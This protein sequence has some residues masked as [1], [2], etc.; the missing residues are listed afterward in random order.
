[1]ENNEF[2]LD[3]I[4]KLLKSYNKDG[5]NNKTILDILRKDN[6]KYISIYSIV[7]YPDSSIY[8]ARNNPENTVREYVDD[9]D[10]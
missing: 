5:I 8:S 10:K 1:V 6:Q 3:S 7:K 4:D 2:S 9:K